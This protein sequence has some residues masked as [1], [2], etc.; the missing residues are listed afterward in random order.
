MLVCPMRAVKVGRVPQ[1]PPTPS[2]ALSKH[3]AVARIQDVEPYIT[4]AVYDYWA[5]KRKQGHPSGGPLLPHLWFEQP[6]KVRGG[7]V[8]AP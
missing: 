5:Q 2:W 7:E 4:E 1:V 3:A 6:W 8:G